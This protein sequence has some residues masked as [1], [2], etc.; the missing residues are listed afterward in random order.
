MG[1]YRANK[2][3]TERSE[4]NIMG[5]YYQC[6]KCAYQWQSRLVSKDPKYCPKCRK[7]LG[8]SI[9]NIS[10]GDSIIRAPEPPLWE[11]PAKLEISYE[12][13]ACDVCGQYHKRTLLIDRIRYCRECIWRLLDDRRAGLFM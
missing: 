12:P 4:E 9:I 5:N 10:G 7:Y 11:K 2:N 3:E 6:P 8:L 13:K 1:H